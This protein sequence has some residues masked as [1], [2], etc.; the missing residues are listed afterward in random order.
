MH[1]A[2]RVRFVFFSLA[3]N[4]DDV[5]MC[6]Q[7]FALSTLA[8][9]SVLCAPPQACVCVCMC[10]IPTSNRKAKHSKWLENTKFPGKQSIPLSETSNTHTHMHLRTHIHTYAYDRLVPSVTSGSFAWPP[11]SPS[12]KNE[13]PSLST[14]CFVAVGPPPLVLSALEL[15]LEY[16]WD[17]DVRALFSL[18]SISRWKCAFVS[19]AIRRSTKTEADRVPLCLEHLQYNTHTGVT[20]DT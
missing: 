11:Q 2:L 9:Y 4:A 18:L 7:I 8:I 5:Q 12:T 20:L 17:F 15:S 16:N 3:K 10:D 19:V 1:P 6:R 14:F 13:T